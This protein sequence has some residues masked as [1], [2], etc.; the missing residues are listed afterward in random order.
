[1]KILVALTYYRPHISGLTIYVERLAQG[2]AVRGHHVTVLT[3]HY[4]K[5]LPYREVMNGVHVIRLPVALKLSKGVIQPGITFRYLSQALEHDVLSVHLPQAEAGAMAILGRFVARKP[6]VL[7]YHCDLQLPPGLFSRVVDRLTYGTN[8]I[9]AVFADRI[10]AYTA[11]Y[12]EHSPL[13]SQFR[14]K[15][16]IVYPPVEMPPPQLDSVGQLRVQYNTNG[17]RVVGFA[18]RFAEE[19]GVDYLINSI[20]FVRERIPSVKYLLAGPYDDVIGEN[21]W[22]RLQ[23]LIQQYREHLEFLGTVPNHEMGN[24]FS[25]CDVLTVPSINSTESF[26]LVQIEAMLSGTPVVAS[27]LPGVREPVRV[28]GMGEIVPIRDARALAEGIV[29][30][31]Q[32][33]NRYIRPRQEIEAMFASER[34]VQSYEQ[35][36]QELLRKRRKA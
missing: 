32:D 9:G 36:F 13:L 12:A 6:V 33:R 29:K 19:K 5:N 35:L 17:H 10:V 20:P 8:W 22:D 15:V 7:T 25:A 1:M 24:F 21:V 18:A 2:L 4:R 28:T 31:I 3:S 14:S 26:G 23:P 16:V 34:T 27:N 11:D 30:V